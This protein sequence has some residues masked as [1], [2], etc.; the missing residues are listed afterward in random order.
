MSLNRHCGLGKKS[1][2]IP[3]SDAEILLTDF[4][5][6]FLPSTTQRYYSNTPRMFHP[7]EVYFLRQE[8]LS[9]PSDIWA[10][11]CAIWEMIALRSLF[12]AFFPRADL[13]IEQHA[14]VWQKRDSHS[15]MFNEEGAKINVC[16]SWEER[17][18]YSVQMPRRMM[19]GMEE[20][21]EEEKAALLS[22]LKA[23]MAF[24]P[25]D[26]MTAEQITG[27]EWMKKWA[28]RAQEAQEGFGGHV[29]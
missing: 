18:E 14:D 3:S 17:F 27:C 10:I 20:V 26:R 25:G 6:S 22:M 2:L 13:M 28:S 5:E 24:K 23:M 19:F 8:P 12:T 29:S 4:G 9:F 1:E 16:C 21:G 15:K 7:P 11:A